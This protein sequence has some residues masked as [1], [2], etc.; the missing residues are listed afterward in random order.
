MPTTPPTLKKA[1][2][3]VVSASG[4]SAG[5]SG[6]Q[7][8]EVEFNPVSLQLQ[9]NNQFDQSNH[10]GTQRAQYVSR[11][12]AKLTLDLP[13]D[14]THSGEDVRVT[15][16]K[17][18]RF[19]DPSPPARGQ[20]RA[21]APVVRFEW[22]TF[23]FTGVVESYRETLDFF[24][25]TGVPLRASVN[26][27]LNRQERTFESNSAPGNN[28]ASDDGLPP[29]LQGAADDRI[30]AGGG[31]GGGA[32]P[33]PPSAP[34]ETPR[35]PGS[36]ATSPPSAATP[37]PAGTQRG[38]A[39][40]SSLAAL[41]G[42][43]RAA[44]ALA[45]ANGEESLRFGSGRPFSL[46]S[47]SVSLSPPIAF[48]SGEAGMAASA[49]LGVSLG[50]DLGAGLG[51]S[52]SAG[53]DASVAAGSGTGQGPA[54]QLSGSLGAG[55]VTGGASIR[56]VAGLARLSATEG[57]FAGL[58]PPQAGVRVDFSRLDPRRLTP[59]SATNAAATDHGATFHPGGRASLE[60]PAGLRADVGG[61]PSGGSLK[62]EIL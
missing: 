41:G 47:G 36:T 14:T 2:L 46:G 43:P 21:A 9:I 53:A 5:G 45:A 1:K 32:P 4:G 50:A 25:S 55:G 60:G 20:A 51:A 49:G 35:P 34:G 58:R 30:A 48:S 24:A 62:F 38:A 3:S 16:H 22:G 52:L 59:R 57:A 13:F 56:G 31:G 15:T 27:S 10:R 40:A 44:R 23:V 7:S 42:D 6:S 33:P 26:L 39:S 8:I 37:T 61:G 18:E 12:T 19:L 54:F 11:S 29:A 28:A 17:L